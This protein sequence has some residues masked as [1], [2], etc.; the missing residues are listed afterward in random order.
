MPDEHSVLESEPLLLPKNNMGHPGNVIYPSSS[1]H[2]LIVPEAPIIGRS[3]TVS[4]SSM[5]D[6]VISTDDLLIL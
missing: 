2:S 6:K 1:S 3:R 4:Q 5:E